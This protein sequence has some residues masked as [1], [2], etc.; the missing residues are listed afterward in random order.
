MNKKKNVPHC[1]DDALEPRKEHG[2]REMD[3]LVWLY[4]VSLRRL[5]R[6]KHRKKRPRQLQLGQLRDGEHAVL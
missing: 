6:I 1:R 4:D 5:T 2:A 3:G